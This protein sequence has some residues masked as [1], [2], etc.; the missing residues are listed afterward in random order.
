[1][2]KILWAAAALCCMTTFAVFTACEKVDPEIKVIEYGKVF[3][4]TYEGQTLYYI[5]DPSGDAAVVPPMFPYFDHEEDETWTGYDKPEGAVVIPDYVPYCESDHPVKKVLYCSFFRCYDITSVT[6]PSTLTF[7]DK[8]SFLYCEKLTS[9]VIPEGVTEIGFGAFD[10]CESMTSVKLPST[11]KSIGD[12]CFYSCL[13]VS[14]LKLPDSLESIGQN[15]FTSMLALKSINL[16]ESLKSIGIGIFDDCPGL[17][18]VTIPT[19]ITE[20]PD[21]T[22]SNC[23]GLIKVNLHD[24]ITSIGYGAFNNTPSLSGSPLPASLKT[25][26][27]YAFMYDKNLGPDIYIPEGV[28]SIGKCAFGKCAG[29]KTITLACSNPPVIQEDTFS[30]YT[31]TVTVPKGAGDTYRNHAIWGHFTSI[32]EN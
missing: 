25:I 30:A 20:L 17:T 13:K 18:E 26:G 6:L 28:T 9:I 16:P 12:W 3:D 8:H 29:I 32:K 24:G 31:A 21:W 22:F 11:L 4:Y 5:V 23:T 14:E 2:K 10:S 19:S 1:M 7:I 27:D 15:C